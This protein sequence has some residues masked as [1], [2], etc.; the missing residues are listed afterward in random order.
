M[1]GVNNDCYIHYYI[2]QQNASIADILV[3]PCTGVDSMAGSS[4]LTQGG[5]KVRRSCQ[6]TFVGAAC[7]EILDSDRSLR[8]A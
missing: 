8:T 1:S 7:A 3:F 5:S 4:Q 6:S 2:Q